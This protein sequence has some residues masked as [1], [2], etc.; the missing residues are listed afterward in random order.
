MNEKI[1]I[2]G[3]YDKKIK[4]W[5]KINEDWLLV[6]ELKFSERVCSLA[7]INNHKIVGGLGGGEIQVL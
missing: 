1:I 2:S 4:I 5:I 6:Q 3:G 7:K